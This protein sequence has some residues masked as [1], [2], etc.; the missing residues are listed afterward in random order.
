MFKPWKGERKGGGLVW[1]LKKFNGT[2]KHVY[3][4]YGS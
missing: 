3:P 4:N 1:G 2:I